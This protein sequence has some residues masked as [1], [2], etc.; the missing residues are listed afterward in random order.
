[1]A[2]FHWDM[3]TGDEMAAAAEAGGEDDPSDYK[4]PFKSLDDDE[5]AVVRKLV[6]DGVI[7]QGGGVIDS[8]PY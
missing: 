8:Y 3:L 4:K 1:M 6:A 5:R 2:L 7:A